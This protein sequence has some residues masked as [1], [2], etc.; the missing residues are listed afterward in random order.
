MPGILPAC[1][2]AGSQLFRGDTTTEGRACDVLHAMKR[3]ITIAILSTSLFANAGERSVLDKV[4]DKTEQV[5]EKTIDKTKE[6]VRDTKEVARDTKDSIKRT[7]RRAERPARP[8]WCT[9]K[10]CLSD[11]L[12]VY[13][14]AATVSLA[15]LGREIA[16]VKAQT[17]TGAPLYFMTRLQSLDE[18]LAL[19]TE[20]LSVLSLEQFQ[21]RTAGPRIDFDQCVADLEEAISQA[22]SGT[23]VLN[24]S[25]LI[26][27]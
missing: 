16:A 24:G 9:T 2:V 3:I 25:I 22:E 19:L 26:A 10:E 14:G 18:Q 12:P 1:P 4:R 27:K 5:V 6:I 15:D 21:L 13:R 23:V 11:Q 7:A 20:R 8:S 17:P